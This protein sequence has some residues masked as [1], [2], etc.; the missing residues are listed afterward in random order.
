VGV[1]DAPAKS[2]ESL[3]SFTT[4]EDEHRHRDNYLSGLRA[5]HKRADADR[6]M[7]VLLQV[8][9]VRDHS[10]AEARRLLRLLLIF[11]C[12]VPIAAI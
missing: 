12:S 1:A 7:P 8:H 3:V 2:S 9:G 5:R 11:K 10:Q 6:P 4:V